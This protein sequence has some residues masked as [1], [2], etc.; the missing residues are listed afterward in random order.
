MRSWLAVGAL[1]WRWSA[2]ALLHSCILAVHDDFRHSVCGCLVALAVPVDL[3]AA[4]SDFVGVCVLASCG[5][6]LPRVSTFLRGC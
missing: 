5:S 3:V 2:F 6:S 1:L 4:G